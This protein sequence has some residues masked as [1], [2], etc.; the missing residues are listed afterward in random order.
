MLYRLYNNK[1]H[2]LNFTNVSKIIIL[3]H[4][5]INTYQFKIA[6]RNLF[7]ISRNVETLI[8]KVVTLAKSFASCVMSKLWQNFSTNRLARSKNRR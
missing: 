1:M 2:I 7:G 5:A 4:E 8:S 3:G 6:R